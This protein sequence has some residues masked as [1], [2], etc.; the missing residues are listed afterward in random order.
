MTKRLKVTDIPNMLDAV[1]DGDQDMPGWVIMCASPK[2]RELVNALFPDAQIEW[3]KR[4]GISSD[5]Y[6]MAPD[7]AGFKIHVPGVVAELPRTNLPLDLVQAAEQTVEDCTPEQL[8]MLLAVGV[9]R[10]GGCAAIVRHTKR[11]MR[12]EVFTP[13]MQ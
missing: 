7:W 9:Q 10:A 5:F 11:S 1:F 2:G 8:A 4:R 12:L 6:E 13:R 3:S